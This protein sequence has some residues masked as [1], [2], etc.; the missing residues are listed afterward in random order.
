MARLPPNR[1]NAFPLLFLA[2]YDVK[3]PRSWTY[4]CI[5]FAA[6]REDLWWW[7][8]QYGMAFWPP[9]VPREVT[10]AAFI[11]A[12]ESEGYEQCDDGTFVEGYE[13]IAIYEKDGDPTHAAKQT[14]EGKWKSKLGPWEDIEHNSLEA[15]ETW[16]GMGGYGKATV[17]MRRQVN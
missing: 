7:P 11:Q 10:V 1:E 6:D 13:K 4:N 2:G 8:D 17:Y 14:P 15:L 3:S 9:G 12:Y 16:A 5:A